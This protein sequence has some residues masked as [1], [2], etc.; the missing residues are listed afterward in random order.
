MAD[1]D[2]DELRRKAQRDSMADTYT[3]RIDLT[4]LHERV[5]WDDGMPATLD[6]TRTWLGAMGFMAT[7]TPDI[8]IVG[9]IGLGALEL[10]EI[11]EQTRVG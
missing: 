2:A 11:L 1:L 9:E 5:N 10:G 8:W 4:L 3:V 7:L 6:Q